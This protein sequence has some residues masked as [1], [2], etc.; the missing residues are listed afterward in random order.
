MKKLLVVV[1]YQVD[2]VCGVLGF[3]GAEKL[4]EGI[5]R[6]VE[7]TLAGGGYVLFTKD[8]HESD[9]LDTREGKFLPVPHCQSGSKG[10]GLYG[11]LAAYESGSTPHV[12]I[13]AKPVFG[14]ANIADEVKKLCEGEPDEIAVCGLVTDLCVSANTVLLHSFF[15][16]AHITVLENLVASAN[17]KGAES[18][19]N[20]MRGMGICIAQ[21][22]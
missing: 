12:A 7:S 22:Q 5:V 16:G 10:Q 14:A 21:S 11:R 19:L 3:V 4:E 17:I 13:I 18:A 15:T 9:Y 2:F 8:T 6:E 20:V 1:D